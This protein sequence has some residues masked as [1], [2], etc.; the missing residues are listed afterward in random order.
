[1]QERNEQTRNTLLPAHAVF[2]ACAH[3]QDLMCPVAYGYRDATGNAQLLR[4]VLWHRFRSRGD[5]DP[6][7]GRGFC[8][9]VPAVP[10]QNP[11]VVHLQ[12]LQGLTGAGCQNR[13]QLQAGDLGYEAAQER[14]R[15]AGARADFQHAM[16]C[17]EFQCVQHDGNHRGLT[18]GLTL[19]NGKRPVF[20]RVCALLFGHKEMSWHARKGAHH[21]R[22]IPGV[23]KAPREKRALL[24]EKL[25]PFHAEAKCVTTAPSATGQLSVRRHQ[26][27]AARG[28]AQVF[29][30]L[31]AVAIVLG[32]AAPARAATGC[33]PEMARVGAYCIDRWEAA[34]VDRATSAPL[35]PYYPPNAKN[36]ARVHAVWQVERL[37]LGSDDARRMPLPAVPAVQ[38]SGAITFMAVSRPGVVPSGYLN[39]Y[40]ARRAC[41]NAGKRL[42]TEEEWTHA[43]RGSAAKKHGY[44]AN[45]QAGRCNVFRPLHPAVVLHGQASLGH[46]DPRLNLVVE[47]NLGPLLRP[48][49]SMPRCV[50]VWGDDAVSDM[51]GNLDEWVAD[52]SGVFLGGFYARSTTQGCEAKVA[53]HSPAYYDYSLGTRCCRDAAVTPGPTAPAP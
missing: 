14:C 33:P 26:G 10:T 51:V 9:A 11:H 41:E 4:Q 6:V 3:A 8:Q 15:V 16:V 47:E 35:S 17:A 2:A 29:R 27:R 46:T 19:A 25:R 36:L 40:E 23:C 20:V 24:V 32:A 39:F 21:C 44:A 50:T 22:R 13:R 43:C 31:L 38:R 30:V 37:L 42:C 53:S 12:T 7:E 5:Q 18:D 1:M 48:T 52:P 28:S 45:Y 49:G 34:L